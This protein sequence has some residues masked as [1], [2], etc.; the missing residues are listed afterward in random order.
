MS[1]RSHRSPSTRATRA[2]P[3]AKARPGSVPVALVVEPPA[4]VFHPP[5]GGASGVSST[6]NV[7]RPALVA[8]PPV[9]WQTI[10]QAIARHGAPSQEEW[11]RALA[12]WEVGALG[13][14]PAEIIRFMRELGADRV[15]LR[16][17]PQSRLRERAERDAD[18]ARRIDE[19]ALQFKRRGIRAARGEALV[20][21]AHKENCTVRALEQRLHRARQ[22]RYFRLHYQK[23]RD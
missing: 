23:D 21:I 7:T 5:R 2:S 13:P 9:D 16:R 19:L 14:P 17:D 10:K 1:A 20:E 18:L 11:D 6:I 3:R 8:H 22:N 4:L 15:R 12:R